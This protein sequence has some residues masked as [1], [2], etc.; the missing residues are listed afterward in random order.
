MTTRRTERPASPRDSWSLHGGATEASHT[1]SARGTGREASR[2]TPPPAQRGYRAAEHGRASGPVERW[3]EGPSLVL[4]VW[5]YRWQVVA[6]AIAGALIG[7]VIA[8]LQAPVYQA[9]TLLRLADPETVGVFESQEIAGAEVYMARRGDIVRSQAV[10]ERAAELLGPGVRA[11]QIRQSTQVE[12]DPDLLTLRIRVQAETA[13]SAADVANEVAEAYQQVARERTLGDAEK[14]MTELR[15]A[16]AS[17]QD[18]VEAMEEQL[19]GLP[20]GPEES[21]DPRTGV[22][23][24]RLESVVEQLIDVESRIREVT[25]NAEVVGSGVESVEEASVPDSPIEPRPGMLALIG[26]MFGFALGGAL[27]YWRAGQAARVW[28]SADVSRVLGAP[29]LGRLP[30]VNLPRPKR[31]PDDMQLDAQ[32]REAFQFLLSSIEYE[33]VRIGGTSI[34]VTSVGPAQG[35]TTTCVHL[36][37]AA[38]RGGER[39]VVLIDG[40]LR[41]KHLSRLLEADDRPGLEELASGRVS[42]EEAMVRR[43]V[44][45]DV[46]V[47]GVPAGGF[48]RDSGS[49]RRPALQEAMWQIRHEAGLTIVDS[50]PLLS[51]ADTSVLAGLVDGV[52]VIVNERTPTADLERLTE[53]MSFVSAPLLGF[54][55]VTNREGEL[56]PYDYVRSR[57]RHPD[58]E[59]DGARDQ[60]GLGEPPPARSGGGAGG[61]SS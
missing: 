13:A 38:S 22:I 57:I 7:L 1:E 34:L 55:Y 24:A 10:M 40:D 54:A 56:R 8:Q 27:A 14:V 3:G 17:L 61:A 25:I 37:L 5:R 43:R 36:A 42:V 12:T 39:Q 15:V 51:V 53:R 50:A 6:A 59:V 4:S 31:L 23:A 47:W 26:G 35:K 20:L 2:D 45:D 48:E 11:D 9:S 46:E 16:E 44:T 58:K 41:A 28:S 30:A 32:T 29:L 33:L 21:L 52:V 18:R 60:T 19:E 49:L